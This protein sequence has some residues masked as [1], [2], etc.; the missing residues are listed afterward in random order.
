MTYNSEVSALVFTKIISGQT[1]IEPRLN[2]DAHRKIKIGDLILFV[3]RESR[4]ERL[5]KV[6]GL[7][8]YDSFVE[9]FHAYPAERFGAE[10]EQDLLQG[11]RRM[12]SPEQ[13]TEHGVLGI[14]VHLL[15]KS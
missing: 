14:K 13:E 5:A 6:V 9:L 3:N 2:D 12:Y 4:E 8:R 15:R 10:S 7:L 1:L 11:M